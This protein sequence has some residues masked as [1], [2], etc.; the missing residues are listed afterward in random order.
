M[1]FAACSRHTERGD[2]IKHKRQL[3]TRPKLRVQT[4][5]EA[6]DGRGGSLV[7][8]SEDD[9]EEPEEVLER[10][11]QAPPKTAPAGN[12][13]AIWQQEKRW[14]ADL[15]RR[16]A[17]VQ[18][19]MRTS[20]DTALHINT[21]RPEGEE[22]VAIHPA[23]ASV[24]KAHQVEG[25]RFMWNNIVDE[26][27]K[28]EAWNGR[29]C[30]LAHTMGLGK[31][32]Q[33]VA[34]LHT[35][36]TQLR[37]C[38]LKTAV[39]ITPRGTLYNWKAEFSKWVPTDS[40]INV[41]IIESNTQNRTQTLRHWYRRGGILLISDRLFQ[42]TANV[43]QHAPYLLDPGPD[44]VVIDEGHSISNAATK[45]HKA[46]VKISTRRRVILTGTPLQ[47]RLGEYYGMAEFVRP[48]YFGKRDKFDE[49]FTNPIVQ[50]QY[51]DSSASE[52]RRMK[53]RLYVLRQHLQSFVHRKDVQE[54]NKISGD[55]QPKYD[56]VLSLKLTM[57]Q[58]RLYLARNRFTGSNFLSC[59]TDL[60]KVMGHPK[61]LEMGRD[62]SSA[63]SAASRDQSIDAKPAAQS[64]EQPEYRSEPEP[65]E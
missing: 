27:A 8:A 56:Y 16:G 24:L 44:I 35:V 31:T 59:C 3:G 6:E 2:V 21:A 20:V 7:Y 42:R 34:L 5:D 39:V 40:P 18:E 25:V 23:M 52:K 37:E 32:L 12:R 9:R 28:V 17:A 53:E 11:P 43:D 22:P 57:L 65:S 30:I 15:V 54:V 10:R 1:W 4:A 49:L 45:L 36:F 41:T 51:R 46:V 61:T 29:G 26:L 55:L 63:A 62:T 14:A 60:Q 64:L 58:K 33:V 13:T 19:T 50:G 38:P 47:N 48:S